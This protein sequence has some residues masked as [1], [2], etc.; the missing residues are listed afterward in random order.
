MAPDRG[1]AG[2]GPVGGSGRADGVHEVPRH[3]LT[4]SAGLKDM[5]VTLAHV[6]RESLWRKI[7]S[8]HEFVLVDALPPLSYAASHLPQ[9]I[10]MPPERVDALARRRIPDLDTEVVVYCASSTC[11]SSLAVAGRL[12]ELG[13]PNVLH[14][15]EGKRDWVEAG[16]P[17][18]GSRV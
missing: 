7:Q 14:Y 11:D 3:G 6:S 5:A 18:E 16:L 12:I 9:A 8:G 4:T 15:A 13:Y 17:L 1:M 10:S 2:R